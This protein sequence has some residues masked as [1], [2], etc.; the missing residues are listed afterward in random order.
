MQLQKSWLAIATLLVTASGLFANAATTTDAPSMPVRL[1]GLTAD[2][3]LVSFRTD[4]ASRLRATRIKG[5]DGRVV[6]IDVRPANGLLYGLTNTDKIYT[7]NPLTGESQLVSTLSIPFKGTI[8]SGIDFNPVP[9]RLRLVDA[10]GQNFRVNVDTG[11]VLS[12]T[13]LNYAANDVNAGATPQITA[14]AYTN[15]FAGPPSPTGVTPPTRT[16]QLFDI[17][18]Y[19]D[20]LVLQNPPNDGTLTTIGPLGIDFKPTGEFDI[21]SPRPDVNFAFAVSGSTF[22]SIDLA[23]GAAV[24]VGSAGK[25]VNL[26]GLTFT[27]APAPGQ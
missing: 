19:R 1:I 14:A 6:G 3:Q 22:Y 9:D 21:F 20:V 13:A 10:K 24:A 8:R 23:T 4:R 27:L 18:S 11:A 2:N 15:A 7:I 16:T 5:V 17:D 26:V 25:G 12:D